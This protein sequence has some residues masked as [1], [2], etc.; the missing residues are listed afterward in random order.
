MNHM[1]I[2]ILINIYIGKEKKQNMHV[3]LKRNIFSKLE[4]RAI[5]KSLD[6]AGFRRG[7]K[8]YMQTI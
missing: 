7:T 8:C 3:D 5:L 6:Q 2:Q 4:L 1:Y